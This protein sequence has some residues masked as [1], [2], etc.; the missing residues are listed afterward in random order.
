MSTKE[1]IVVT[2]A[3]EELRRVLRNHEASADYALHPEEWE[4]RAECLRYAISILKREATIAH[5]AAL[6]RWQSLKSTA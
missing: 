2:M 3:L 4:L 5:H 1:T 6:D